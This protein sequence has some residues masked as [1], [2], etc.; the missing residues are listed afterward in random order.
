MTYLE[1][2]NNILRRLRERTVSSVNETAYS[3]LIG[4]L[5]NDALREVENAWDWSGLRVTLSATTLPNI[6]SYELN[7]S[8]DRV[9]I[10]D[11]INDTDNFFMTYRPSSWL[12]NAF[13]NQPPE[14]ASPRYYGYNG[15][16]VDGDTQVDVYPIPDKSY[17][18]RFNCILRTAGLVNDSD[19]IFVPTQPV[20]LLAYAKAIEERGEDGGVMSSSA[21]TTATKALADTV[22]FDAAKHTEETLWVTV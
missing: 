14:V 8:G 1:S 11:V 7:G 4:V 18:L 19:E 9:E 13:L 10:L 3:S 20:L 15:I 22:S 16:S 12:N 5:V 6:F 2:V 21:Y 17:T